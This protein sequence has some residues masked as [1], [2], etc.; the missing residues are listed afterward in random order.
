MYKLLISMK[1][2]INYYDIRTSG[3][4]CPCGKGPTA[5]CKHIG[6]LCYVFQSFCDEGNMP[7]FLTCTLKLQEWNKPCTKKF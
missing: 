2:D 6:P 7:E 5:S 1:T 3:C 4:G